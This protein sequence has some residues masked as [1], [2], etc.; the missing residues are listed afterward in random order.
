MHLMIIQ[1]KLFIVDKLGVLKIDLL[2]FFPFKDIMKIHY[3]P[4]KS[5]I[6]CSE[7]FLN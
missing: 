6:Y 4:K 3:F 1:S 5:L 2:Y 7:N